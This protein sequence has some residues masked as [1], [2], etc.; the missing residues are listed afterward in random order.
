MGGVEHFQFKK[1]IE[2][3]VLIAHGPVAPLLR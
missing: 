1:D 3:V 2:E